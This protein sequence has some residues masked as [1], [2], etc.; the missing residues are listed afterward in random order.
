MKIEPEELL[1]FKNN[2][3]L[4]EDETVSI[5]AVVQQVQVLAKKHVECLSLMNE[6]SLAYLYFRANLHHTES[7]RQ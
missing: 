1:T 2:T 4:I 5:P 3:S 7:F 6:H